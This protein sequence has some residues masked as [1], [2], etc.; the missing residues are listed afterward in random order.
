MATNATGNA[1]SCESTHR[2]TRRASRSRDVHTRPS[3]K[4]CETTTFT[5]HFGL[6][7]G[8]L[9]TADAFAVE[10]HV[11]GCSHCAATSD[12]LRAF[13]VAGREL[14]AP[15]VS[16]H[17]RDHLVGSGL[18]VKTARISAGL[19][20]VDAPDVALD[21]LVTELAADLTRAEEVDLE[22]LVNGDRYLLLR[23]VPFEK[24]GVLFVQPW[25]VGPS[26]SDVELGFRLHSR[27]DGKTRVV[28][29]Y[30]RSRTFASGHTGE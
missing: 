7:T 4:A 25:S 12:R 6:L 5:K 20:R 28:A 23:D 16:R 9:S 29:E 27:R 17:T 24:D 13:V 22:V 26:F 10:E 2:P 3:A 11:L 8:A 15:V 19:R 18:R 14:V 30:Q 21:L 1:T